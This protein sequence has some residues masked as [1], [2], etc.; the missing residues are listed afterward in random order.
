MARRKTEENEFDEIVD[1]QLKAEEQYLLA[2]L[3]NLESKLFLALEEADRI[4]YM[5]YYSIAKR[6]PDTAKN[7]KTIKEF[8]NNKEVACDNE[9]SQPGYTF[10][11]NF[12]SPYVFEQKKTYKGGQKSIY[13]NAEAARAL[14]EY[15]KAY[16]AKPSNIIES[17]ILTYLK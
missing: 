11:N 2:R 6:N 12:N 8:F 7:I 14:D 9:Q 10:K 4:Q 3:N 17:L 15:A 5:N 13:L 1:N 16:N